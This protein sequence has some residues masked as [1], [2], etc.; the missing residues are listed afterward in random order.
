M[1][2]LD[3]GLQYYR[4]NKTVERFAERSEAFKRAHTLDSSELSS[5][6]DRLTRNPEMQKLFSEQLASMRQIT[7]RELSGLKTL[8]PLSLQSFGILD[9]DGIQVIVPIG[10]AQRPVYDGL[11]NI[12]YQGTKTALAIVGAAEFSD[13]D[14]ITF[15][16]V[17]RKR[18]ST[19][20]ALQKLL[21]NPA[22][23]R[24]SN[25]H[26]AATLTHGPVYEHGD[27]VVVK[28][29][30]ARNTQKSDGSA[31]D[32]IIETVKGLGG[33]SPK[34]ISEITGINRTYVCKLLGDLAD[35]KEVRKEGATRSV[36]YYISDKPPE[37]PQAATVSPPTLFVEP[38]PASS[39]TGYVAPRPDGNGGEKGPP[40]DWSARDTDP[41]IDPELA[42]VLYHFDRLSRGRGATER[43]LKAY[44]EGYHLAKNGGYLQR[45]GDTFVLSKKGVDTRSLMESRV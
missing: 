20:E 10:Y 25:V 39:G 21:Y 37:E 7:E 18:G 11:V 2:I 13:K 17:Q 1:N 44:G 3:Y 27:P 4:D 6:M 33:A 43:E 23:F 28:P 24:E 36:K 45:N 9:K 15:V 38:A 32:R 12:L 26:F 31:E 14:G 5:T 29:Y 40:V 22:E 16:R 42:K 35:R 19:A 41:P 30:V 34:E 8:P